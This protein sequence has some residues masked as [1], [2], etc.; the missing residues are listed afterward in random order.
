[1]IIM[2]IHSVKGGSGL[3]INYAILAFLTMTIPGGS[4]EEPNREGP[5]RTRNMGRYEGRVKR[6][7]WMEYY[8]SV[9]GGD[10]RLT[11]A[12]AQQQCQ[13]PHEANQVV[14]P[15]PRDLVVGT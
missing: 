4:I 9:R 11:N 7:T 5:E 2:M 6:I 13:P 8:L 12:S 10:Q 15:K 14:R 3:T 1:M